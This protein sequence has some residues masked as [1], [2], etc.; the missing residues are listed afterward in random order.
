M[1]VMP[2]PQRRVW[3]ISHCLEGVNGSA[4][5]EPSIAVNPEAMPWVAALV[6]Q[7]GGGQAGVNEHRQPQ[8]GCCCHGRVKGHLWGGYGLI[9]CL[10]LSHGDSPWSSGLFARRAWFGWCGAVLGFR[11]S[12]LEGATLTMCGHPAKKLPPFSSCEQWCLRKKDP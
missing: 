11:H 10:R 12:W 3:E 7:M 5:Q 2:W 4:D 8:Q 1:H 6:T 9:G